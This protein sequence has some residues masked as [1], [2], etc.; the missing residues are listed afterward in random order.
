MSAEKC[1]VCDET[2]DDEDE[3]SYA[4]ADGVWFHNQ[5]F[6]CSQ[7]GEQLSEDNYSLSDGVLYCKPHFD[8]KVR[9]NRRLPRGVSLPKPSELT[10]SRLSSIFFKAQS[11]RVA[12]KLP[13]SEKRKLPLSIS[14]ANVYGA[15]AS[16]H[17]TTT[18][19]PHLSVGFGG[20]LDQ[21]TT[22]NLFMQNP[23]LHG[24]LARVSNQTEINSQDFLKNTLEQLTQNPEMMNALSQLG[25]QMG[26]NQ[27]LGSM[28]STMSC[29]NGDG[30]LDMSLMFQQIMPLF[31]QATSSRLLENNRPM[32]HERHR[33]CYSDTASINC[34]SIDCQMNIK[35]AA[36]KIHDEYPALDI[37]SS[38]VESVALLDDNVYDVYGLADLC[39]DEE[40]AEEFMVMLK[41]DVCRRLG[42][43]YDSCTSVS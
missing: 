23:A 28:F 7:C 29:S 10:S 8:E 36:Q 33:R 17:L 3:I 32:K 42:K 31:S 16:D 24:L 37:F 21:I 11:K 35:E 9:N 5:C 39:S 22:M 18:N 30:D 12:S 19:Q 20:Q 38:M 26:D 27:D 4:A 43:R 1:M 6:I 2:V 15:Y 34:I 41:R 40:L 14:D 13:P 25:Q